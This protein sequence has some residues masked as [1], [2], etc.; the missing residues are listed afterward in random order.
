[1]GQGSL[2]WRSGFNAYS[3]PTPWEFKQV[4]WPDVTFY[5]KQ[6]EVIHSVIENKI[7]VVPAGHQLGKD[8]VTGFIT[9]YSFLVHPVARIITTSVKDDHL[10]VLWGEIGRFIDTCKLNLSTKEG[11]SLYIKHRELR[12]LDETGKR[13]CKISYCKGIVSETGEGLAGHHAPYTLF[14]VDEA[15]GVKDVA[16]E[17]TDSWAKRILIL[18]NPYQCSNFFYRMVKE[19][20]LLAS[21]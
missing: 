7:T 14:I 3:Y 16:Y 13:Q 1:M 11:G 12:K 9:L 21:E 19:G 2:V 6:W 18:G 4:M 8:F 10:V 5:N 20:D 15:S 17:R